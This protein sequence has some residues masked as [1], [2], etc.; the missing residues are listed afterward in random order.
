[1]D[2][3]QREIEK[4]F[5]IEAVLAVGDGAILRGDRFPLPPL[6]GWREGQLTDLPDED[7]AEAVIVCR[8]TGS[9]DQEANYEVIGADEET[10]VPFSRALRRR[11]GLMRL[12]IADRWDRDLRLV[13]GGALD[14]YLDGQQLR[15]SIL[16]AILNTPI[17][18]RLDDDPKEALGRIENTFS[19]RGLPHPVRLGL[20]GTPGV[21]LAASVG[22]M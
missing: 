4:G 22:L 20:V 21:S 7:G 11:V 19:K 5:E 3:F 2:Y 6:R 13:Q 12:D 1:F 14:R 15:Q 8:L 18:A 9:P 16:Q 17:H 10:R